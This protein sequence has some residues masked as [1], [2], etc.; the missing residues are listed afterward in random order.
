M[1]SLAYVDLSKILGEIQILGE[2]K[3]LGDCPQKSTPVVFHSFSFR[4][5]PVHP[6]YASILNSVHSSKHP[7]L[8]ITYLHPEIL[9]W[10]YHWSPTLPQWE[11]LRR[12][13]SGNGR[14]CV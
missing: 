8:I 11:G 14:L 10:I 13:R 3:I 12:F 2:I 1:W 6:L 9:R 5:P 4:A 7:Q